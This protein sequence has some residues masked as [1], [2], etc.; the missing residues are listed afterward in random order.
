MDP[1]KWWSIVTFYFHNL[2]NVHVAWGLWRVLV[3]SETTILAEKCSSMW[4]INFMLK[5]S[6]KLILFQQI[7]SPA[8]TV[9]GELRSSCAQQRK[10]NL[11]YFPILT[12]I[13]IF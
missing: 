1:L 10:W 9:L 4:D 3:I 6:S 8:I 7:V 5:F 2:G 11:R 12:K 13:G